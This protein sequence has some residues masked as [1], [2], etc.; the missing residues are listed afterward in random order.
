V[1]SFEYEGAFWLPG[2]QDAAV[3]GRIA[4]EPMAGASLFLYGHLGNLQAATAVDSPEFP[5][6][7]GVAGGKELVLLDCQQTNFTFQAPGIPRTRYHVRVVLL[8]AHFDVEHTFFDEVSIEIHSLAQWARRTGL[9]I[10]VTINEYE[11]RIEEATGTLR[12]PR[13]I[14]SLGDTED[15]SLRMSY[16]TGGD[17]FN[18]LTLRSDCFLRISNA[19]QKPYFEL[20]EDAILLQHLLTVCAG[21]ALPLGQ[22][23]LF[24]PDLERNLGTETYASQSIEYY[25]R[26]PSNVEPP[27][28]PVQDYEMLFT[29]DQMGGIEAVHA[30]LGV[31]RRYGRV[32]NT[33]LSI[34]YAQQIYAENRFQNAVGAAETLHR[35]K[36]PNHVDDPVRF[37]QFRRSL[38][39][40]VPVEHRDWLSQQLAF[41]N[42]PRLRQRLED[43]AHDSSATFEAI[44]GG[45]IA[46]W[47]AVV[48]G[49]RNRLTHHDEH[50][51]LDLQGADL[52]YLSESLLICLSFN[53]LLECGVTDATLNGVL[54]NQRIMLLR[55]RLADSIPRLKD[56]LSH[57]H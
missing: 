37:R 45:N 47:T 20:I 14:T 5:V 10:S 25:S 3:V 11:Q 27:P 56:E 43:L 42:E 48:A 31:A 12:P 40:G 35:L 16:G 52:F 41:S 39:R 7:L 24:S 13:T 8:G 9:S 53:L 21:R 2:S 29:L 55:E 22:I 44:I 33:L 23:T 26:L 34:R 15:V 17:R 49:V 46:D 1:D 54:N 28:K 57:L 51:E 38:V 50:Q 36:Y 30:W 6:A 32:L 18:L 19:F 4:F